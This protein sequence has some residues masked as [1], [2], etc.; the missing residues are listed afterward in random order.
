MDK[1]IKA[2]E[3]TVAKGQKQLKN[4]EALDKKR[5]PACDYGKAHMP[6]KKK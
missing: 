4:L 1:K 2:V 6:K 3:K 5:D